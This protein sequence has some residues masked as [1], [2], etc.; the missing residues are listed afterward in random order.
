MSGESRRT[1]ET[2]ED[3]RAPG[4][5]DTDDVAVRTLRDEDLDAIVRIDE[6]IGGRS[7]RKYFEVKLAAA[8]RET[9]VRI[10]L[11]AELDGAVAGFLLGSVYYGE[12]GR[13]EPA[14][15]IDTIGVHPD[16]RGRKVGKALMRQLEMNMKALGIENLETQVAWN[17]WDLLRFLETQGFEPAPSICLRRR[18]R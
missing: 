17:E 1:R 6:R 8:L 3:D 14:A 10:S 16:F 2:N 18:L 11:V 12:F 9:G 13:P 15:T 7:R 5:L 4:T